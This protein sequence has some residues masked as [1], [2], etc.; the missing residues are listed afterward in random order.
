MTWR[1]W[2]DDAQVDWYLDRMDRLEPRA[3][4]EQMLLEAIDGAPTSVLDL[5][6]G[7]GR[8]GELVADARPSVRTVLG[9]DRSAPMLARARERLSG[10]RFR[11]AEHDLQV[12]IT[13][14][15]RFDAVVS[16][17]AIHHL[18]DARKRE[19]FAEVA[20]ILTGGGVFVNLEVVKS[21]TA[22]RHAEFLAAIGRESDDPEDRLASV[23]DQ[24]TW[25][26]EAGLVDV[27]CLWRWRGFAV[28]AGVRPVVQPA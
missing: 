4:G 21:A 7:D 8:L 22:R 13:G 2:R 23:E 10:P 6:C 15:G 12:P 16:G 17:F 19:L 27:E 25:M 20:E 5:G 1:G 28:L 9:V 18:E 11:L 3:A 14:L 24:V 26:A